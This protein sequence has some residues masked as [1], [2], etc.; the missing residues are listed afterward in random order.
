MHAKK[1]GLRGSICVVGTAVTLA[2][3]PVAALDFGYKGRTENKSVAELEL[4]TPV[5]LNKEASEV[6]WGVVEF[7]KRELLSEARSYIETIGRIARKK[8]AGKA[9]LEI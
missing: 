5:E 8:Q 2:A 6:C 9:E 7:H 3:T 4:M 1:H